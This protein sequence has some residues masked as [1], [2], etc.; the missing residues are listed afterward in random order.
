MSDTDIEIGVNNKD[1]DSSLPS[2]PVEK[3]R[4]PR[5]AINATSWSIGMKLY[6]TAVPCFL[7]F[8]M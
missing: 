5:K 4:E 2:G 6:H 8:V 7:S 1:S 3:R